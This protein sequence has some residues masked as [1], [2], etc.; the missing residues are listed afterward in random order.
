MGGEGISF[1][2]ESQYT[3]GDRFL[4][5]FLI[6]SLESRGGGIS[7][8]YPSFFWYFLGMVVGGRYFLSTGSHS[9]RGGAPPSGGGRARRGRVGALPHQAGRFFV[10][11][12]SIM[13]NTLACP[14]S[15]SS[16]SKCVKIY[17]ISLKYIKLCIEMC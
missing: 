2:G 7:L 1:H 5:Y 14:G 16:L 12:Y 15:L 8:F 3:H 9:V 17:Q 6:Y 11:W 13:R 10:Q 4:T